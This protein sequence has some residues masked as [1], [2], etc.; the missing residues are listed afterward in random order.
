MN[1]EQKNADLLF[2][3]TYALME[4]TKGNRAYTQYNEAHLI[5]FTLNLS[6][7]FYAVLREEG[8]TKAQGVLEHFSRYAMSFPPSVIP[9]AMQYKL[10]RK[11]D[12]LS[13][14]DCLGFAFAQNI[15]I[16]FL[17]GDKQF[18]GLPGVRFVR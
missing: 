2:A 12:R 14:A 8:L 4:I 9:S 1:S 15:S 10:K 5:T 13:Y 17:T 3:D 11:A 6:E 18:E 7:L 16:P